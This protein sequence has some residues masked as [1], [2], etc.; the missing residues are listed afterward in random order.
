MNLLHV[1]SGAKV[2]ITPVFDGTAESRT[3]PMDICGT[4]LIL[5]CL[6][7]TAP[8]IALPCFALPGGTPAVNQALRKL[9]CNSA[10]YFNLPNLFSCQTSSSWSRFE[11]ASIQL[12]ESPRLGGVE[13]EFLLKARSRSEKITARLTSSFKQAAKM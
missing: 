4:G 11:I 13:Q 2:R 3:L 10:L 6:N 12:H 8:L 9:T 7:V 1:T 5:R